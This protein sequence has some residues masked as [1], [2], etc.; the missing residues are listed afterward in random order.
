LDAVG[1]VTLARVYSAAE[2]NDLFM[3][4]V[5]V[6]FAESLFGAAGFF[7]LFCGLFE[8]RRVWISV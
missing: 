1:G 2:D 3:P 4:V 7:E 6:V 5:D 8:G